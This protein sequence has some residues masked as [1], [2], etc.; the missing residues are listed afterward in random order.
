MGS[1]KERI[2]K[3]INT[4]AY[5]IYQITKPNTGENSIGININSNLKKSL[6]GIK[7][8][9]GYIGKNDQGLFHLSNLEESLLEEFE[10]INTIKDSIEDMIWAKDINGQYLLTNESF[11]VKF[12]YGLSNEEILGKTDIELSKIFKAMVGDE[13]HTFGE[14]CKNSDNVIM[15]TKTPQKFLERGNIKGKMMKLMVNK[16]PIFLNGVLIGVCGVG[17]DVTEWHDAM[18]KAIEGD[19]ACFPETKKLILDELNKYEFK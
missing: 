17:K 9:F 16:T 19:K 4:Q 1:Y 14:L 7:T 11:R 15:E 2:L 5:K 10:L 13:N 18:E 3:I 6:D 12:C 8:E